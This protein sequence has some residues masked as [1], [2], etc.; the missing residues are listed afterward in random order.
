MID[1]M[2]EMHKYVPTKKSTISVAVNDTEDVHA[3]EE[4]SLYP[5]LFGGDQLSVATSQV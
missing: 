3:V 4:E 1:I 5:L 2:Q